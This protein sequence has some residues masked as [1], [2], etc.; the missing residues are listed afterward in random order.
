MRKEHSVPGRTKPAA[1][2]LRPFHFFLKGPSAASSGCFWTW[3]PGSELWN[4]W[5]LFTLNW[6]TALEPEETA[7]LGDIVL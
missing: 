1:N 5:D 4:L 6:A 7:G 2:L 3:S